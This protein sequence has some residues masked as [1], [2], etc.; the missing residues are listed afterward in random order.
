[1]STSP[2]PQPGD[3]VLVNSGP[4]MQ[5]TGPVLTVDQERN[6]VQLIV[7]IFG[8]DTRIEVPLDTVDK[9]AGS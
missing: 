7:Q 3:T 1:M 5:Y 4:F 6:R 8:D 2:V 9:V